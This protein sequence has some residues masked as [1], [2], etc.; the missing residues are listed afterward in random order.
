MK[1]SDL[2]GLFAQFVNNGNPSACHLASTSKGMVLLCHPRLF[3]DKVISHVSSIHPPFPPST[4]HS[5]LLNMIAYFELH[6]LIQVLHSIFDFVS[7]HFSGSE[8]ALG[9]WCSYSGSQLLT[10][11]ISTQVESSTPVASPSYW[12]IQMD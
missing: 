8:S 4:F 10:Y 11:C 6:L 12:C 1:A 3:T 2:H 7:G 5:C 9:L